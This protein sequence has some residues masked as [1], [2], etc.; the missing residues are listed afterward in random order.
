MFL[1]VLAHLGSPRHQCLVY[2][3]ISKYLLNVCL[4]VECVL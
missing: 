4:A 1:L 3:D 2:K